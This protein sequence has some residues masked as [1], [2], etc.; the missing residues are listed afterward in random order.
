MKQEQLTA[1]GCLHTFEYEKGS[2]NRLYGYQ[3]HSQSTRRVPLSCGPFH[4]HTLVRYLFALSSVSS[5]HSGIVDGAALPL[6]CRRFHLELYQGHCPPYR[7]V[8][9]YWASGRFSVYFAQPGAE[10]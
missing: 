7:L 4:C 1:R 3:T 6:C 8:F 5:L 10:F 9:V 2:R